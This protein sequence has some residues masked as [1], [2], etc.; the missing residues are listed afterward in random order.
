MHLSFFMY[1]FFVQWKKRYFLISFLSCFTLSKIYVN[2][3]GYLMCIELIYFTYCHFRGASHRSMR[4]LVSKFTRRLLQL[5]NFMHTVLMLRNLCRSPYDYF[6]DRKDWLITNNLSSKQKVEPGFQ[7]TI[8]N[9][10]GPSW[11][12]EI[13]AVFYLLYFKNCKFT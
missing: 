3:K 6:L 11:N 13:I 10:R 5:R 8:L 9:W 7:P 2:S 4:G 12:H 1:L